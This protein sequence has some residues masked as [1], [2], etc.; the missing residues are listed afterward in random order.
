MS[1]GRTWFVVCLALAPLGACGGSTRAPTYQDSPS[2]PLS[3]HRVG[4]PAS[5]STSSDAGST[6]EACNAIAARATPAPA[7]TDEAAFPNFEG[8]TIALGTYVVTRVAYHTGSGG[9]PAGPMYPGLDETIL[10]DATTVQAVNMDGAVAGRWSANWSVAGTTLRWS[11]TCPDHE[12]VEF[13]FTATPTSLTLGL[14]MD[15]SDIVV[16]YTKVD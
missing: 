3:A 4:A 1:R 14:R 16:S 13:G 5:P 2:D 6:P 15:G 9:S 7:E 12:S 8:G 10:V 11:R